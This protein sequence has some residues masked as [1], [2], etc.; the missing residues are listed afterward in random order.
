VCVAGV[1][2]CVWQFLRQPQRF[3]VTRPFDVVTVT[4]PYEEVVYADLIADIIASPVRLL[5]A[6]KR[7]LSQG[8]VGGAGKAAVLHFA[9][10]TAK[11][12]S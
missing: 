2:G 7:G 8:L 4:P 3:G 9:L 5:G 11:R 6:G 1:L 10:L 12:P